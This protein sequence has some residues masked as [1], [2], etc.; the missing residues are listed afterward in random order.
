MVEYI[1]LTYE[2]KTYGKKNLLYS[3]MEL[4]GTIKRYEN[5]KKLRKQE[6]VL[7]KSLKQKISEVHQELL[8]FDSLLPKVKA[9]RSNV[10]KISTIQKKRSD[11]QNEIEEL[12]RKIEELS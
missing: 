11:L 8:K 10:P 7:K 12:K 1:G 3:Q 2:Q 6:I 9:E 5:Y 4:L